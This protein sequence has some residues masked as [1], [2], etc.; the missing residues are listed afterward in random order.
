[1]VLQSSKKG[2]YRAIEILGKINERKN[3]VYNC[4]DKKKKTINIIKEN[5]EKKIIVF[6]ERISNVDAI[7]GMLKEEKIKH[8][9]YHSGLKAKER[10]EVIAEFDKVKSGVLL[11][12]KCLDEGYDVKSANVAIIVNGSSSVRQN[13]QR[14][15]R[16]LRIYKGKEKPI[17]YQI[18]IPKTVDE[19]WFRLKNN[20]YN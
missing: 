10:K 16:V 1:M 2:D 17:I 19:K 9:V 3:V 4:M 8:F 5:A 14:F 20:K 13:I 18:Y 11:T 15:G 12:A 6:D 7:A